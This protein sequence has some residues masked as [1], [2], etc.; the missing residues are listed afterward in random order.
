ME[1]F[2]KKR[3]PL[4][5]GLGLA[6][7]ITGCAP[8]TLEETPVAVHAVGTS[9][10]TGWVYRQAQSEGA[11]RIQTGHK[12]PVS[13]NTMAYDASLIRQAWPD[14]IDDIALFEDSASPYLFI[15]LTDYG[16]ERLNPFLG[17][18]DG[19]DIKSLKKGAEKIQAIIGDESPRYSAHL[20][21]I[22]DEDSK[23]PHWSSETVAHIR[24][25]RLADAWM[26]AGTDPRNITAQT[27]PAKPS[28]TWK[29]G[30]ALRPYEFG[31]ESI[32]SQL[33]APSSLR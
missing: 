25:R 8:V 20:V 4:L 23:R 7:L 12:S 10:G 9:Q 5:A 22:E 14:A 3:G 29:L 28:I 27:L 17:G 6:A 30:I 31:H 33:I 26:Q 15:T 18:P 21:A 16:T 19:W 2:S 24:L 1:Q 13:A 11:E 32:N